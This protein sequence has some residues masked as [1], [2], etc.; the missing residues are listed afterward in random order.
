[1]NVYSKYTDGELMKVI[2]AG[3]MIAF[4]ELYRKYSKRL[5]KFS[6]SILK[7]TEEAENITQD[8]FLNLWLNREKVE[9]GSSVKYYIFTIAYNSAISV[10]R[11]KIKD[12]NF[13]EYL[14]THQDLFQEPVDL[15]IEYNELD[16]KLTEIVNALPDRQ[17][18]VYLL[19][20]VEGLKY[21]EIAERLNISINTVENH[22]SKA[23]NTI[24]K[25]LGNYS[26]IVVLFYYLFV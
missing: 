14:K 2:K 11:K 13:I 26:L 8:V 25:K 17:R 21:T 7:T 19:N 24:R 10:I 16:E 9:K 18:K 20:R 3:N 22:I 23:L 6:Y 5:Y 12:S 1:M 15:Q 4:D